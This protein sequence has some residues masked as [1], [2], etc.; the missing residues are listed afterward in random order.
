MAY[1]NTKL[2]YIENRFKSSVTTLYTDILQKQCELEKNI[3]TQIKF[4]SI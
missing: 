3:D 2:V 4:S 1:I